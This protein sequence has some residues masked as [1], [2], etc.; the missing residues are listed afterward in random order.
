MTIVSLALRD[1]VVPQFCPHL[2]TPNP[3]FHKRGHLTLIPV[4]PAADQFG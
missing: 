3:V 1:G 2:S 4:Q